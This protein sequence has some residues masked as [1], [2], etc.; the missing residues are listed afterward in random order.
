MA[1]SAKLVSDAARKTVQNLSERYDGYQAQ[2]VRKFV[3]VIRILRSQPGTSTQ[4]KALKELVTS[5]A[6]EVGTKTEEQR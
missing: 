3:D 1:D 4:R 5:F 6:A 2:L